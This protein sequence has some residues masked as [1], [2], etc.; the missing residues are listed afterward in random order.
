MKRIIRVLLCEIWTMIKFLFLKL[1][2]WKK[3]RFG[4]INVCSPMSE[5][6]I[7]KKGVLTIG[8]K[9]RMRSNC[10]L[11]V[12]GE[13]K[14]TIGRNVTWNYG[15]MV[16]GHE[17]IDI[18]NNVQFGPNVLVYDHD[19]DFRVQGGLNNVDF[20]TK[21]VKI[22]NNV[23]IGANVVILRGTQIGDDCVVASGSVLNGTYE[24]GQVIVQKRHTSSIPI[25]R[26]EE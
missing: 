13:A 21:P 2:H 11:R 19:H 10:H 14:V 18:G 7:S 25:N 12:R 17:Q 16:V 4:L 1:F 20:V 24:A 5:V 9:F 26:S 3:F 15:C 8:E 22:G 6:D 23:W